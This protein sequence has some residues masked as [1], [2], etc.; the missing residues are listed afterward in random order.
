MN[1]IQDL[2][3]IVSITAALAWAIAT[4]IAEGVE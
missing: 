1:E 2:L 3:L 4:R